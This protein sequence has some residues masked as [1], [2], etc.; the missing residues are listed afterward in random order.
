MTQ[1]KYGASEN[2]AQLR[3]LSHDVRL[4]RSALLLEKNASRR[5][6]ILAWSFRSPGA[7]VV[8]YGT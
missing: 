4:V 6:G 5:R 2:V 3:G 1:F 8:P 7:G